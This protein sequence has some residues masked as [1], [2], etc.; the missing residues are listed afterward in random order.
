MALSD[1]TETQLCPGAVVLDTD[2]LRSNTM[3]IP[4]IAL[5]KG[6]IRCHI[7]H[8][9]CVPFGSLYY[10]YI[11]LLCFALLSFYL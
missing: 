7:S 2:F 1:G 9:P 4:D 10:I 6:Y 11:I 3:N 8:L 5:L